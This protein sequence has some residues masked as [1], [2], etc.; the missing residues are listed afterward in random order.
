MSIKTFFESLKSNEVDITVKGKGGSATING[1][2]VGGFVSADA[3]QKGYD[4]IKN[5][6]EKRGLEIIDNEE[7]KYSGLIEENSDTQHI[8]VELK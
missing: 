1:D 5:R 6:V 4:S 2:G 8:E 7:N 3:L